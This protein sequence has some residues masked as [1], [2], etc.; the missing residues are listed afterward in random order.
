MSADRWSQCPNC[1]HR[2]DG[3]IDTFQRAYDLAVVNNYG[4]V[5][6][7]EYNRLNANALA[8]LVDARG[9]RA[10]LDSLNSRTFREDYQISIEDGEVYISYAASCAICSYGTKFTHTHPLPPLE[11]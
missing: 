11:E 5:S 9:R 1:V 4:K 7:E 2:A 8:R 10:A 3:T 6:L